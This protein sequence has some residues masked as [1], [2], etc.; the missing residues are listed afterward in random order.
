MLPP[1]QP[2]KDAEK[3]AL[4]VRPGMAPASVSRGRWKVNPARSAP[5][6]QRGSSVP[7]APTKRPG[8]SHVG[9]GR[10]FSEPH[11]MTKA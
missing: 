9:P 6:F 3:D 5:D 8:L 2:F 1:D 11:G 10:I 4:T 7:L